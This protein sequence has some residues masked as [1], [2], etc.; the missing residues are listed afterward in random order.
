MGVVEL[1]TAR[2]SWLVLRAGAEFKLK[3]ERGEGEARP[4]RNGLAF[5]AVGKV[6]GAVGA[7][8]RKQMIS[9]RRG[10]TRRRNNRVGT[11]EERGR[12]TTS[13]VCV[14]VNVGVGALWS[15]VQRAAKKCPL[16]ATAYKYGCR[17]I[18][19]ASD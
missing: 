10:G 6:N 9:V 14:C 13:N 19:I 2:L 1:Q 7:R 3:P 11:R 16:A 5:L 4:P 18:I 8:K 15:R 17:L 12:Y